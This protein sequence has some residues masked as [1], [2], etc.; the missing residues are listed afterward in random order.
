MKMQSDIVG[1]GIPIVLVPGGLTGWL[2]WEP[3]AKL[4]STKRKVIR[5]QLLNVQYGLENRALP[6][7][8]SV[9]TE[10]RALAATLN[11]LGYTM[12]LDLVAWSYGALAALDYAL[13]HPIRIRTLTLIEPPALWVLRARGALDKQTEQT[14]QLLQTLHGDISEDQLEA[15]LQNVGFLKPRQSARELPQWSL[16]VRHRQSLRNSPAVAVHND[17]IKRLRT[18][19]PQTLLVKGTGSA[20]FLHQIIDGL[21]VAMPHSRVIEMPAGHAPQIVSMDRFLTEVERFQKASEK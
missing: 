20:Q 6:F 19:Q 12:P 11:E 15:F 17:E 9:K 7:D 2:S 21:G 8:Y 10:S 5:V 16:W 14:V 1:E 4:L 3:H 18:F 13:D